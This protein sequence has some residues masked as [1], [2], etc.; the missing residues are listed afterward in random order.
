MLQRGRVSRASRDVLKLVDVDLV[1]LAPP[2]WLSRDEKKVFA[3]IVGAC[4]PKHFTP[5]D[6]PLLVSFVQATVLA[7][8][9]IKKAGKDREALL[10]WERATKLQG[11][12]ATKL[13]LAP[14]SR[15]DRKTVAVG[16]PSMPVAAVRPWE[17]S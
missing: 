4:R 6:E 9:A 12:L 17:E 2:T 16:L 10:T 11:M 15:L 8:R 7:R 3:E 1:R 5:S 13:R 14:Q